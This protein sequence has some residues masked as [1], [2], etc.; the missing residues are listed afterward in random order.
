MFAVVAIVAVLAMTAA[1]LLS[2]LVI[3]GLY[4]V[5]AFLLSQG[6]QFLTALLIAALLAVL[7]A[8]LLVTA[9]MHTLRK[10]R[11]SVSTPMQEATDAFL[12]GLLSNSGH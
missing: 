4:A 8:L 5:Y 3:G 2:A 9:V 6:T 11:S 12:D 1:I 7:F 10:L